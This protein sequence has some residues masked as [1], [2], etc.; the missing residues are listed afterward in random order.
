[1][2]RINLIPRCDSIM[3]LVMLT[4]MFMMLCNA[5]IIN[6]TSR[7]TNFIPHTFTNPELSK[8]DSS[9]AYMS[10]KRN[11]CC[12]MYYNDFAESWYHGGYYLTTYLTTLKNWKC[13][14]Y[15]F[16]CENP[17][18]DFTPFTKLVYQ[19]FCDRKRLFNSCVEILHNHSPINVSYVTNART[20]RDEKLWRTLTT[21]LK[22][23]EMIMETLNE[24]CVQIALFDR[25]SGGVG[26]FHEMC[27]P[28]TLFGDITWV[29]YDMDTAMERDISPWDTYSTR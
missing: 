14:E 5:S 23:R 15:Q 21:S 12:A 17:V 22:P 6:E 3:G 20:A 16:E 10:A 18:Y 1:M 2:N 28:F 4:T 19:S 7:S 29:G 13:D 25:P 11:E 24:P 8:C 9:P 27:E 26:R